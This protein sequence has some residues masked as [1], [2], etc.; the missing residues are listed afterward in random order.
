MGGKSSKMLTIM[1]VNKKMVDGARQWMG[2]NKSLAIDVLKLKL[3]I[4]TTHTHIHKHH[5]TQ[6]FTHKH[7]NS[8]SFNH[9]THTHRNQQVVWICKTN[10][11][12][13]VFATVWSQRPEIPPTQTM[14][15]SLNS[16]LIFITI[17]YSLR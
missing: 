1:D 14:V 13:K 4:H 3:N 9:Q 7:T 10:S 12:K 15:Q 8:T 11:A 5:Y 2:Q 6:N 17:W 16:S